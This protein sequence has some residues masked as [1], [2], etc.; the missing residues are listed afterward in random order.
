MSELSPVYS[1]YEK[2]SSLFRRLNEAALIARQER[3]G[4]RRPSPEK[5]SAVQ[6]EL[7]AALEQLSGENAVRSSDSFFGLLSRLDAE[8][9]NI[10]S[11]S[12]TAILR[13]VRGGLRALTEEDL[14]TIEKVAEF[15]D[16][17]SEL[18]FRR[19]QK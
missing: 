11:I 7:E 17:T 4:I 8:D 16:S 3:L 12:I 13:R 14:Q 5:E 19:I 1:E 18:L 15:L 10:S 2:V 6:R 9:A